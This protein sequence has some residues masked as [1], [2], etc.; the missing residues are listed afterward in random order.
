MLL[1]N[2]ITFWA[3]FR[4][5]WTPP[6][7]SASSRFTAHIRSFGALDMPSRSNIFSS[8]KRI[9]KVSSF[10]K[11]CR[12]QFAN[13]ILLLFSKSVRAGWTLFLYERYPRSCLKIL[14]RD[15]LEISSSPASFRTD[16]LFLRFICFLTFW[17]IPL[18]L[19]M[20]K[21][22]KEWDKLI[23]PVSLTILHHRRMVRELTKPFKSSKIFVEGSPF[24]YLESTIFWIHHRK[25]YFKISFE[26]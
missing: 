9:L 19:I 17:I 11:L 6:L 1:P 10:R 26:E 2:T 8:E 15:P 25:F 13:F 3:N 24:S 18:V 4:F 14:T 16:T 21:R 12:T 5:Y 22:P 23:V 20:R 7:L